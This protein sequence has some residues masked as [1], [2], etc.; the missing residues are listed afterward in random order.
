[1]T[2]EV[3]AKAENAAFKAGDMVA[4]RTARANL[5]HGTNTK[6]MWQGIQTVTDYKA[7]P[8]PC[9]DNIHFLTF[10]GQ[11]EALNNTPVRKSVPHSDEQVLSL[12]TGP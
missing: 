12:N 5:N 9:E 6:R 7:A 4:L 11:F 3:R 2:G 1:M 8:L 10:F